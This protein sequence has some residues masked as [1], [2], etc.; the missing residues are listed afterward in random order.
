MS[1]PAGT[2]TLADAL[3]E[4]K[5]SSGYSY[6]QIGHRAHLGR[7]T[8]HRYCSGQSVPASFG[9]VELIAKVCGADRDALSELYRLWE[10]ANG[11]AEP[12]PA[13]EPEAAVDAT[14]AP[15][16]KRR[17]WWLV[18]AAVAVIAIAGAYAYLPEDVNRTEIPAQRDISAP[19]W[20]YNPGSVSPGFVGVTINSATGAMPT[21][22]V[23]SVR[24]WDSKTRWQVLEPER[25]RFDWTILDR[26]LDGAGAAGLPVVY[27]FGG[28]PG[29][30]APNGRRTP[31]TDGSRTSPPDDLADWERFVRALVTHAD[32]RIESYEL[33]DIGTPPFFDGP[34]ET[35]VA[36]TRIAADVIRELDPDANVVCPGFTGLWEPGNQLVMQ[37]FAEL[38]GYSHCD[39]AAVKLYPRNASD[40]PETMMELTRQIDQTLARALIGP[41]LWATGW[42]TEVTQQERVEPELAADYAVRSYL[43][44]LWRWYDRFYFYSWGGDRVPIV[45]QTN[46]FQPTKAGRFVGELTRWLTDAKIDSCGHGPEAGLPD[47][48]WQC[49]FTRQGKPFVIRW[50]HEG[51]A[52]MTP[53]PGTTLVRRLDGTS[54]PVDPREPMEITGRPVLLA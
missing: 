11:A 13:D 48:V 5:R 2:G 9:T 7:S 1:R 29:W 14:P 20:T 3:N 51:T 47:N 36:M 8:V 54:A 27:V 35:L 25:G 53:G 39:Y 52:R 43:V 26:H 4:L 34:V 44:S 10:Q 49:R 15:A 41:K 31:Y 33:W 23:G 37:R 12:E 46:G 22:P 40:P 19:N 45:L 6:Q 30:A 18:A 50:T 42:G 28:A 32:G 16:P 24:L 21:F 17:R 38:G